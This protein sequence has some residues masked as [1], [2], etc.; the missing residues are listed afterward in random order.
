[1]LP[2][3]GDEVGGDGVHADDD[4][5]EGEGA[6]ATL[7]DDPEEGRQ[8]I[9]AEASAEERPGRGPD[10]LDDG[11]DAEEV[12]GDSGGHERDTGEEETADGK[13][14]GSGEEPSTGDEAKDHGAE[15]GDEAEGEVSATV[16]D[17]RRGAGKE[18]EEPEVE[19][20]AEVGVLVPVGGEAV[21]EMAVP[22][23]WDADSGVVEAD[24]WKRIERPCEPVAEED[25]GERG[26]LPAWPDEGEKEGEGVAEADL[27]EGVFQGDVDGGPVN[28]AKQDSEGDENEAALDGV[29][30][31][32]GEG[33]ALTLTAAEGVGESDSDE[34]GEGGLDEVVKAEPGPFDVSLVEGEDAPEGAAG[35][36]AGDMRE[37][38]DLGHHEEHDET[39]VGVD[40]HV[41]LRLEDRGRD[42]RLDRAPE[43]YVGKAIRCGKG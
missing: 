28:A 34:K 36:G 32:A 18:V 16:V 43:I 23:E 37:A 6:V 9:E 5:R 13:A 29:D 21:E 35:P 25:G 31:A 8:E 38:K 22:V 20:L 30:E 11:V 14:G 19:G 10:A 27:G 39:A 33:F 3:V 40:C 7:F 41:A 42:R 1:M 26:P 2:Q 15:G 24:G 17:K 4:E 12:K